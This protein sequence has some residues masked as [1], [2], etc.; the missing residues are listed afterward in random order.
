MLR[1]F[2]KNNSQAQIFLEYTVVCGVVIMILISMNMTIKRGIQ[3]MI[4][5]AA[6]QIGDQANSDQKFDETGHMERQYT[7]TRVSS[8]KTTRDLVGVTNYIYADVILSSTT[9]VVNLGFTEEN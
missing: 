3:G 7:S 8:D 5:S 9:T 2:L 6:D 1:R 4:K